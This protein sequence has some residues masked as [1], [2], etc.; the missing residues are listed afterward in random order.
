MTVK[1]ATGK[2]L[3]ADY[4]VFNPVPPRMYLHF[5][6]YAMAET[7]AIFLNP[8]E[9]PIDGYPDYTAVQS[10]ADANGGV[11]VTLKIPA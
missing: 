1:T 4:L 7:A 8:A 10:I 9:L 6:G 3:E 2:E 5:P 11:N